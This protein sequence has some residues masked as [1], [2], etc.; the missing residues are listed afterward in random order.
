MESQFIM[1]ECYIQF[2]EKLY[3]PTENLKQ[4]EQNVKDAVAILAP[5]VRLGKAEVVMEAPASKLRE[6][7]EH[8]H[9][10]LY[11]QGSDVGTE[12]YALRFALPDKGYVNIILY[13]AG[14]TS[15][16]DQEKEIQN[17]LA[18]QIFTQFSRIMM[19][20]FLTHVINTDMAT[21]VAN[22]EAFMRFV[23][24][25]MKQQ[26]L[27]QY[28]VFFF[29]IHNFKY[30]NKVFPYAEGD[31]VLR[32]YAAYVD[33]KTQ[34]GK[35]ARLGGDNFV[36]L[37]RNE[38]VEDYIHMLQNVKI[39][40]ATQDKKKEFLFSATIGV[41][42]LDNIEA[43]RDVL[44]HASI[45]Y[46]AARIRG[47][48]TLV[49]YS[50]EIHKRLM[51]NQ[52]IISQFAPALA[53]GEFVVYYQPKVNI[54]DRTLYGAEALVRWLHEGTLIPPMQFV[55]QLER[56]GSICKLDYYVL[57][58]VC[59]FLQKRKE[60]GKEQICISVNFSR[61]HLEEDDMV[62]RIVA[63]IDRYGIDHQYIEVE[64]TESEDFQ[65]YEIMSHIVNGLRDH[66]IGTSIDDF[67]TEFSS[68]NM[69]KKV[70]LNVIKIDKSFIPLEM[71]YPGKKKDMI[72]FAN[73]IS[74]VS[75]LGKKTIVEGV[76]TEEQLAYLREVGCDIVQGYVF[77][78]PL[79]QPEFEQRLEE[80][81]S[82]CTA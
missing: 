28:H 17:L 27:A 43:P 41:S 7:E 33:S 59:K 40:H 5:S 81:Y 26:Q 8:Q 61:K 54:S 20:G 18:K 24:A 56:E 64:L 46:Q 72:M 29:N 80:G 15:F 48:G 76:E 58:Q 57:E 16:S 30:V 10:T 31:V 65:N 23:V 36:A 52:T 25:L 3:S 60:Q 22:Q 21:G 37:V 51:A 47:V 49:Y 78:K 53:A 6:N 74:L 4:C 42:S 73:I 1:N 50:E 77:D 75:Q 35:V 39:L 19:Q 13:P 69:I 44:A 9:I 34:D 2:L 79:P 66:G 45:A 63:I 62:E 55:P 67:G 71:E 12:A 14:M 38:Q 70:D 68:L 82:P 32:K 11:D